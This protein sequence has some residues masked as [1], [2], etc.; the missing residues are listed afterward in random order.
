MNSL[1]P[2][3]VLNF[4]SFHLMP[5]SHLKYKL[6]SPRDLPYI[7]HQQNRALQ[8]ADS[9]TAF[10]NFDNYKGVFYHQNVCTCQCCASMFFLGG[11]L[12]F[13][14]PPNRII[15]SIQICARRDARLKHLKLMQYHCYKKIL[16]SQI[17]QKAVSQH[18][19]YVI[20]S[21]FRN[22]SITQYKA[23]SLP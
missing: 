18:F 13:F 19:C 15:S 16:L 9:P 22:L 3:A 11:L 17:L 12:A 4:S 10:T 5:K 20:T 2:Q 14:P 7:R 1:K 23:P 8:L 21:M 6:F